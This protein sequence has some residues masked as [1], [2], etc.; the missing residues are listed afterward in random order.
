MPGSRGLSFGPD[1]ERATVRYPDATAEIQR[2]KNQ[3]QG[4]PSVGAVREEQDA[5]EGQD[6]ATGKR[7]APEARRWRYSHGLIQRRAPDCVGDAHHP[8]RPLGAVLSLGAFIG[9]L[10]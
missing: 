6:A 10:L 4:R 9:C 8:R 5:A 3:E 7:V 2:P 1:S